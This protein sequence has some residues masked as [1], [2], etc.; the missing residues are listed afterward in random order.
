MV[1][2]GTLVGK[3]GGIPSSDYYKKIESTNVPFSSV[4][5]YMRE[6]LLDYGPESTAFA[7]EDNRNPNEPGYG[8]HSR[9]MLTLRECGSRSNVM[10]YLPDGTFLDHEFMIR[11]TR[12]YENLPNM[13]EEVR[14]R[15]ARAK[16]VKFAS[17]ADHSVPESST[18][19]YQINRMIRNDQNRLASRLAIF[20]D[21]L[22]TMIKPGTTPAP[23]KSNVE[24]TTLDGTVMNLT[25]ST[26][27]NKANL[28]GILSNNI[29]G[30]L[31][32]S[33]PDHRV[34]VSKYGQIRPIQS[35]NDNNWHTNRQNADYNYNKGN[36]TN[37]QT[38][39]KNIA[40]NILNVENS[41]LFT[42]A[43][44][45][46]S[47]L[48]FD[49]SNIGYNKAPF[50]IDPK[51]IERLISVSTQENNDSNL[52]SNHNS[53]NF[54][55]NNRIVTN[56]AILSSELCET[57]AQVNKLF[58]SPQNC[59]KIRDKVIQTADDNNVYYTSSNKVFL[60]P[61]EN[62]LRDQIIDN[63]DIEESKTIKNYSS[64]KLINNTNMM[65]NISTENYGANSYT[66][67]NK[68]KSTNKAH[69]LASTE[70]DTD[71]YQFREN[72]TAKRNT[73]T[74]KLGR[75]EQNLGDMVLGNDLEDVTVNNSRRY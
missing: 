41:R 52:N 3:Y 62:D 12:N 27:I 70:L 60:K 6:A 48:A 29:E 21:S 50:L 65:N 47:E 8:T 31:R 17:D 22:D 11:D 1:G 42:Q 5:S 18:N 66:Q 45:I 51:D 15:Y 43:S 9:D 38:F 13:R 19:P 73:R 26:S 28:V 7:S 58:L 68:K 2:N 35:F 75:L 63:R 34:K 54:N 30:V 46:N 74:T 61:G 10:P 23:H 57:I 69:H 71:M 56:E 24:M 72:Y 37:N 14:H 44:V 16:Y 20:D 33:T 36:S 49:E 55:Y 39:N 67:K 25:D 53:T 64:L 59:E 32:Y 4:N 40:C